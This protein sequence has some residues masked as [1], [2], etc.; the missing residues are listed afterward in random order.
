V[1]E[2][3]MGLVENGTDPGAPLHS[4]LPNPGASQ[5][6]EFLSKWGEEQSEPAQA[7]RTEAPS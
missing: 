5:A 2:F 6:F 3:L 7:A 1:Q 4:P